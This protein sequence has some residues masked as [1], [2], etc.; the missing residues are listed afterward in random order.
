MWLWGRLKVQIFQTFSSIC[1]P[2]IED[3]VTGMFIDI[4]K[5]YKKHNV[6]VICDQ[7]E[8]TLK[9]LKYTEEKGV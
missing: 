1:L 9:G 6:T 3:F 4:L 2:D 5:N 7:F 8:Q